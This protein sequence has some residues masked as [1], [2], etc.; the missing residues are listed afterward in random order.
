M[1]HR[2]RH[3]RPV[4]EN[5][6]DTFRVVVV[7]GPRQAGKSTLARDV[8]DARGGSYLTLDDPDTLVA[9]ELDPQRLLDRPGPSPSTRCSAGATTSSA[10]SRWPST[11]TP[12]PAATSSR[13]RPAS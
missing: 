11:A 10:G 12:Y 5:L 8:V 3:L 13:G 6:L 2:T 4:I 9:A 1:E 7:Q